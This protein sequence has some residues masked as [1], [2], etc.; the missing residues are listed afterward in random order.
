MPC[1]E[2]VES[3][4][5]HRAKKLGGAG[6]LQSPPAVGSI[7]SRLDPGVY[8]VVRQNPTMLVRHR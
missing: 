8:P 1:V 6:V 5:W 3:S 2:R 7:E 4:F